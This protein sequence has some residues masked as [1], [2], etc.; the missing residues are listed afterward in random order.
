[1]SLPGAEAFAEEDNFVELDVEEA[2]LGGGGET[3]VGIMPGKGGGKN[4]PPECECECG[5]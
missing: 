1:M 2:V 3:T 4:C 5:G